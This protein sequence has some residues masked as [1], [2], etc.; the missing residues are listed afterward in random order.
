V[1]ENQ[2][3][4]EQVLKMQDKNRKMRLQLIESQTL[5]KEVMAEAR[6][7][8]LSTIENPEE[9]SDDDLL[10]LDKG[11]SSAGRAVRDGEEGSEGEY[12]GGASEEAAP[13]ADGPS[14]DAQATLDLEGTRVFSSHPAPQ[15][16]TPCGPSGDGQD[17]R[18]HVMADPSGAASDDC[19]ATARLHARA[20]RQP[21]LD[22]EAHAAVA[23]VERAPPVVTMERSRAGPASQ[24]VRRMTVDLHADVDSRAAVAPL[25]RRSASEDGGWRARSLE[26]PMNKLAEP[27]AV[28]DAATQRPVPLVDT[29]A[30]LPRWGPQHV[31]PKNGYVPRRS[32]RRAPVNMVPVPEVSAGAP[33]A[34][35]RAANSTAYAKEAIA[36][37]EAEQSMDEVNAA[38][39]AASLK[40]VLR[41][42]AVPAAE[43][44]GA[45]LEAQVKLEAGLDG[46]SGSEDI[47][48]LTDQAE[49]LLSV[50][51]AS[52]HCSCRLSRL[53]HGSV[54]R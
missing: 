46:G 21:S 9:A 12:G 25:P 36:L 8:I 20:A 53:R 18:M 40:Q 39:T 48:W 15:S 11:L 6:A 37:A 32:S 17:V 34:T 43:A 49:S 42:K 3:M 27:P 50:R 35:E 5:F 44:A 28:A 51:A 1:Q 47:E 19:T 52:G 45:L 38:R 54:A 29:E 30:R 22:S 14:A 13:V 2:K 33:V 26:A 7:I 23:V 4:A 10:L 31:T 24:H 41:T 16:S